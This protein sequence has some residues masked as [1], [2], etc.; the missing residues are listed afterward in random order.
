MC[1]HYIAHGLCNDF[2]DWSIAAVG[3]EDSVQIGY[4]YAQSVTGEEHQVEPDLPAE[5]LIEQLTEPSDRDHVVP[6]PLE[7][8]TMVVTSV[9]VHIHIHLLTS[10]ACFI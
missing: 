4:E 5:Q 10:I 1:E 7:E 9:E 2:P 3:S 6:D 8:G